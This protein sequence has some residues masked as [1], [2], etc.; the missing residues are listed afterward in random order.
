MGSRSIAGGETLARYDEGG[1]IRTE[2]EEELS[3]DVE[4]EE[5]VAGKG[6][7]CETDNDEEDGEHGETHDLNGFTTEGVDG[8]D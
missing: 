4:R 2:V 1:R 8:S 6:I 5:S 7:V 3:Q